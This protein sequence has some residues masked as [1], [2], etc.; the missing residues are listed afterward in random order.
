MNLPTK[1]YRVIWQSVFF[2]SIGYAIFFNTTVS[3]MDLI[4]WLLFWI[5]LGSLVGGILGILTKQITL[6]GFTY[7]G[8]KSFKFGIF[9]II[10]GIIMCA[11]APII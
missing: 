1:I 9:Y 5:G 4:K 10:L 6:R 11:I 7:H 8:S 2:G 3:F